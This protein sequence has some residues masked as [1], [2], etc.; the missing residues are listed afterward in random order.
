[1]I[2]NK[3]EEAQMRSKQSNLDT[4]HSLLLMFGARKLWILPFE[5]VW[6]R[7]QHFAFLSFQKTGMLNYIRTVGP[8]VASFVEICRTLQSISSGFGET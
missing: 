1:M 8:L 5:S 3:R 4:L 6:I 2:K 7:R